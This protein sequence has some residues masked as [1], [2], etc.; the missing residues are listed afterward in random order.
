MAVSAFGL[1]T[2]LLSPSE[3]RTRVPMKSITNF[4]QLPLFVRTPDF[5]LRSQE[6][7]PFLSMTGRDHQGKPWRVVLP[8]ASR[9]AW[10]SDFKG[11][12]TYYFSGYTGGAGL[13]PS[14][15]ILALSFD[16]RG[17]PVPFYVMTH[18][19]IDDVLDLDGSG[20]ELL[21]QSYWGSMQ[22]DPGYFVT[23][24]YQK[25]GDYWYR[26]DGPHGS[27]VFPAFERWSVTWGNR[28]AEL[29]TTP[30]ASP[31]YSLSDESNDPANGIRLTPDLECKSVLPELSVTDSA[32]GRVISLG[33]EVRKPRLGTILTGF[34]RRP[35]RECHASILWETSA[36]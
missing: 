22:N 35:G 33:G 13:A 34:H 16:A 24:I 28:P 26:S 36:K 30:P 15:W 4:T 12:R 21:Q 17:R 10:Q 23:V 32:A 2:Q 6:T 8:D 1:E 18:G 11:R 25:K 5:I 19:S 7:D 20:P 14:T 27:H 31:D 3:N 29:V 9:E